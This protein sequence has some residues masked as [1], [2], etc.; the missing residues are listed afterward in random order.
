MILFVCVFVAV[1]SLFPPQG[2]VARW[3]RTNFGLC[4][5][6]KLRFAST[7]HKLYGSNNVTTVF[8]HAVRLMV[9]KNNKNT[10]LTCKHSKT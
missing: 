9:K 1:M 6:H 3:L 4:G 7:K 8:H 2:M 10:F 5:L